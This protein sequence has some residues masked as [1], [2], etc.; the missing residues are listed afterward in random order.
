MSLISRYVAQVKWYLPARQ[1][2]DVGDELASL[3]EEKVTDQEAQLGRSL[4]CDETATLLRGFGHPL[5]VA[6]SYTSAGPLISESLLPLYWL[7][8]RYMVAIIFAAYAATL[9]WFYLMRDRFPWPGFDLGHLINLGMFY[10]AAITLTFHFAGHLLAKRDWLNNWNPTKLPDAEAKREPLYSSV[11]VV[12]LLLGWFRL[13]NLIPV[14]HT[15]SELSGS[16]DNWLATF[17]LW[18]KAQTVLVLVVYAWL[19]FQPHW[20]AIKRLLIMAADLCAIAGGLLA[21]SLARTQ[22][23]VFTGDLSE[24]WEATIGP[25]FP[26]VPGIWLLCVAINFFYGGLVLW[27]QWK[28][29]PGS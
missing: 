22:P 18:L 20:S 12:L 19:L 25:L 29:N 14:E 6:S 11:L 10:F 15:V 17:V 16:S 23:N 3:L 27:R 24:E 21:F 2:Q 8:V 13:L 7:A 28:Y 26:L 1:R 9:I 5:S 4:T